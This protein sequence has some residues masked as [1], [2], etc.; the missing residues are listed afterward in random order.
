MRPDDRGWIRQLLEE[1][2]NERMHLMIF[3]Q[4]AKPNRFERW[5]IIIAQALFWHF[6]MFLYIFFPKVAHRM[7]AYFEEQAVISYTDYL[8]QIDKGETENIPAP[9][10]AINYYG[11]KKDAT[12]RDVVI[13]VRQDERG[14][15]KVNH[16]MADII[17]RAKNVRGSQ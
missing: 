8:E 2:E 13:S 5:M 6:Y 17:K 15:A 7:V 12:L 4:I 11:L 9:T 10:I 3:I 14:H 16:G 1:A